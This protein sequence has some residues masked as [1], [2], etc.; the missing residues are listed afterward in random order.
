MTVLYAVKYCSFSVSFMMKIVQIL[1]YI[2]KLDFYSCLLVFSFYGFK[3]LKV[4]L[5]LIL[6]EW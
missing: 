1:G 3:I 4:S 5:N 2:W 6:V